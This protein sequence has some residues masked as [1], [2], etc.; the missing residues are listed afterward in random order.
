MAKF[1]YL[2]VAADNSVYGTNDL[3]AA[4]AYGDDED[5]VVDVEAGTFLFDG[6]TDQIEELVP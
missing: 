3:E 2:V 4:V 6:T 5:V 1:K